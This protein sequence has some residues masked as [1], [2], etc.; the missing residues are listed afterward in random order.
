MGQRGIFAIG[1]I[2]HAG[3]RSQGKSTVVGVTDMVVMA[4]RAS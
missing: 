4:M 2:V 1:P 3:N